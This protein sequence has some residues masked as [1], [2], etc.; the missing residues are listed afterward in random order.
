MK[1]CIAE[2]GLK[3]RRFCYAITQYIYIYYFKI[4]FLPAT[5]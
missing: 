1:H 2:G 4:A 5:T 3:A